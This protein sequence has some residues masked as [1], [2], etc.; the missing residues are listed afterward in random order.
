[1]S[2]ASTSEMAAFR[3]VPGW[4][5]VC[6]GCLTMPSL[7]RPRALVV[8]LTFIVAFLARPAAA[9]DASYGGIAAVTP[10]G[11][12]FA[13]FQD[14]D[15]G[16]GSCGLTTVPP[17]PGY[18]PPGPLLVTATCAADGRGLDPVERWRWARRVPQLANLR[19]FRR[20]QAK[21]APVRFARDGT[22][23]LLRLEVLQGD[24]WLPV[25]ADDSGGLT[26]VPLELRG[27]SPEITDTSTWS[28]VS[29]YVR[30]D[31]GSLIRLY[32]DT[33]LISWDQVLVVSD[34]EA[35]E[36]TKRFEHEAALASAATALLRAEHAAHT[37]VFIATPAGPINRRDRRRNRAAAARE[38]VRSWERAAAFRALRKDDVRDA[39]WLIAFVDHPVR[40]LEAL[41]W[42]VGLGESDRNGA[43]SVLAELDG[44]VDTAWLASYLRAARDPLWKLPD[45]AGT[46]LTDASLRDLSDENI[47]WLHLAQWAAQ[48][49]YRFDDPWIASY[50]AQFPWYCPL[51]KN[52]WAARRL[53]V[54][55]NPDAGLL[56]MDRPSTPAGATPESLQAILR[57]ERARGMSPPRLIGAPH[58]LSARP[59]E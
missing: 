3:A 47:R 2:E 6:S 17:K 24:Q 45:V 11:R 52:T 58:E 38:V 43:A 15:G 1:M 5:S 46:I 26:E 40:R 36:V 10:D 56:Q 31:S 51:P 18:D 32:H 48:G 50:F 8:A 59:R 12:Y 28:Y 42:Y 9:G 37:G 25:L 21:D 4:P 54:S 23:R 53:R 27:G 34:A 14:T 57:A 39:L 7:R 35:L 55:K 29:G 41:R 30:A 49:G 44:D 16:F 19:S 20:D 33:N 22:T 13:V